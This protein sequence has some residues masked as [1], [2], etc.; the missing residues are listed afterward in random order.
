M[1]SLIR[2]MR[3]KLGK[4]TADADR[5]VAA[6][7]REAYAHVPYYRALLDNAGVL[8]SSIGGVRDLPKLPVTTKRTLLG[9]GQSS[10]LHA[11]VD[12]ARCRRAG[13]SGSQ[14]VPLTIYFS[15]EEAL[16]RVAQLWRAIGRYRRL[17]PPVVMADV[18][19]MASRSGHGWMERSGLVR[20]TRLPATMPLEEQ[21]ETVLRVQPSLLEG[22]P[23]CLTLLAEAL[24]NWPG[25]RYRPRLIVARGE[26]LHEDS[27]ALLQQVFGCQVADLY[28]CEEIGN[29]A[30]RCPSGLS[31]W[32]V[33]MDTCVL[34][35]VD[36]D[37]QAV[38]EGVEGRVL[39]TSLFGRAMPLIRYELGD[40]ATL[41]FVDACA[42][43]SHGPIL[44]T[45]S[46]RDDDFVVLPDGQRVSPRQVAT[47]V[48][49]ALSSADSGNGSQG[50]RQFQI[51]QQ[52]DLS[53][54]LR[55]VLGN[56]DGLPAARSAAEALAALGPACSI[57]L[58]DEIPFLPSGKLKKVLALPQGRGDDHRW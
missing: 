42:C 9:G 49:N 23:T 40:R 4:S 13:T 25:S 24:Q 1:D 58:V 35:V 38:Q 20:L 27:R 18:G 43:G 16:W 21:V 47:T 11:R 29:V 28:N 33:N 37:G 12:P 14:G 32:H 30:W 56:A 44:T 46:G 7:V 52:P 51:V 39:V 2:V 15:R 34:E 19:P 26:V 3:F 57:E 45:L 41:G 17:I 48:Y 36:A 50:V 6:I 55:V 10:Y 31:H 53:L 22:Y 8:P 5:A 54:V